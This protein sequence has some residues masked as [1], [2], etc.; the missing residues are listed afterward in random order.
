MRL[1]HR[2]PAGQA[3]LAGG[4]RD[5]TGS[6][7]LVG[8]ELTGVWLSN[9]PLDS[10]E[11]AKGDDLLEV[12]FPD[13]SDLSEFEIVQDGWGYREWCVPAAL[14]N[15]TATVRML[16]EEEEDSIP[17]DTEGWIGP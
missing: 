14:I 15:A 6:Y 8:L 7:M 5:A 4:F 2:T 9:V 11:G 16:T 13:G 3:I 1:Y 17:R 10:N 12:T